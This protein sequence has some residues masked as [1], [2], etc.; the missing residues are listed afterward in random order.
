MSVVISGITPGSRAEMLGIEAGDTLLQ[1]NGYEINDILDF[2]FYETNPRLDITIEDKDGSVHEL[3]MKKGQY[4]P[5]GLEFDS[6]LM[7]E[8]RSCRNKCVFCFIDQLPK[9]MRETLYY[10]DDDARLSFIFGNYVTLTNMKES[11]IDR[12]IRMHISPINI[13][14]HTMNPELRCKMMNNRFAGDVLR[15]IYKLAEAGIK[16]NAQ[17]VLCPGINDGEELRF[18]LEEM[19]KLGDSLQSLACVPVGLTRYRDGLFPLRPYTVEEANAVIDMLEAYGDKFREERGTR[20][21]YPSDEFYIIA[22]RELPELDFYEDF[23]Q[24]ENGVGMIRNLQ[25]EF[26]WATEDMEE[27]N[28]EAFAVKRRAMMV[29]GEAVAPYIMGLRDSLKEKAPNL[30]VEIRAIKNNFFGGEINVTGLITGTDIIDQLKDLSDF[31]ELLIPSEM[32]RAN[33]DVFLDD[34]SIPQLSEKLNVSVRQCGTT[35][36]TILKSMLG[37]EFETGSR[38]YYYQK[39]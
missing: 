35:G 16:I 6:F 22:E 1:I 18:T 27:M 10:K 17:L 32:I 2:R 38:H 13:S 15:Y 23:P 4:E 33:E 14:V 28:P 5:M 12:I 11:E 24:I 7:D 3:K 29:T 20:T 37:I 8:E 39:V 34:I 26:E 19:Y 31:D 36:D 25:D 9:G 30:E 21:V